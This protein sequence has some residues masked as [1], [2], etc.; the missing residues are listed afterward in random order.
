MSFDELQA[1]V[2]QTVGDDLT[3]QF[4][5]HNPERPTLSIESSK[6]VCGESH[7]ASEWR[8]MPPERVK[9]ICLAMLR[10]LRA[11]EKKHA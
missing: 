6:A 11:W 3:A 4:F 7:E 1:V 10:D 5:H 2:A 9:A 8:T